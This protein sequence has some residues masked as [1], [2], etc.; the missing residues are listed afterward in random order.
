MPSSCTLCARFLFVCV[1]VCAAVALL[2]TFSDAARASTKATQEENG[3][4]HTILRPLYNPY[5]RHPPLSSLSIQTESELKAGTNT[6]AETMKNPPDKEDFLVTGYQSRPVQSTQG[7]LSSGKILDDKHIEPQLGITRM[8]RGYYM[9]RVKPASTVYT[10][11][12]ERQRATPNHHHLS[13]TQAPSNQKS[14]FVNF[15]N[16]VAFGKHTVSDRP[17][18]VDIVARSGRIFS[19]FPPIIRKTSQSE[20]FTAGNPFHQRSSLSV[21]KNP[22][23]AQESYGQGKFPGRDF[24]KSGRYWSSSLPSSGG[25]YGGYKEANELALPRTWSASSRAQLGKFPVFTSQTGPYAPSISNGLISGTKRNLSPEKLPPSITNYSQGLRSVSSNEKSTQRNVQSYLFTNPGTTFVKHDTANKVMDDGQ[26]TLSGLNTFPVMPSKQSPPAPKPYSKLSSTFEQSHVSNRKDPISEIQHFSNNVNPLYNSVNVVQYGSQTYSEE[27]TNG[28][29]KYQ[30][31]LSIYRSPLRTAAHTPSRTSLGPVSDK[32]K[33]LKS[34]APIPLVNSQDT[35]APGS[36]K[37]TVRSQVTT[38][39]LGEWARGSKLGRSTKSIYGFRGFKY[40][41][42]WTAVGENGKASVL[43][44]RG[45]IGRTKSQRYSFDKTMDYRLKSAS[46]Y[47]SLFPKYGFGESRTKPTAAPPSLSETKRRPTGYSGPNVT[48]DADANKTSEPVST[49]SVFLH[50]KSSPRDYKYKTSANV[51]FPGLPVVSKTSPT[52]GIS[53]DDDQTTSV[54]TPKAFKSGAEDVQPFVGNNPDERQFRSNKRIHALK[55]LYAP[56]FRTA[57]SEQVEGAKT[58]VTGTDKSDTVLQGPESFGSS[59]SQIWQPKSGTIQRRYEPFTFKSMHKQNSVRNGPSSAPVEAGIH[60]DYSE[61]IKIEAILRPD[62]IQ[63][64]S[65]SSA[66]TEN[67]AIIDRSSSHNVNITRTNSDLRPKG[68]IDPK[69]ATSEFNPFIPSTYKLFINSGVST[70]VF[71]AARTEIKNVQGSKVSSKTRL[72]NVHLGSDENQTALTETEPD[73]ISATSTQ[74]INDL[75]SKDLKSL[76]KTAGSIA[77]VTHS[78]HVYDKHKKS[79]KTYAFLGFQS[80]RSKI[81]GTQNKTHWNNAEQNTT[82]ASPTLRHSSAVP[83]SAM[84]PKDDPLP[85]KS[86]PAPKSRARNNAKPNP[87]KATLLKPQ[88]STYSMVRGNRVQGRIIGGQN[89]IKSNDTALN[90]D[91]RNAPIFR[92]PKHPI[93]IEAIMY[94]DILGSA[95]FS[96]IREKTG[97]TTAYN[98]SVSNTTVT[99]TEKTEVDAPQTGNVSETKAE[100]SEDAAHISGEEDGATEAQAKGEMVDGGFSRGKTNISGTGI[101]DADNKV[102]SSDALLD[103]EGSGGLNLPDNLP[104]VSSAASESLGED[105]LELNYL[106]IATGNTSFKSM[107]LSHADK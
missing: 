77:S 93:S 19:T 49:S 28:V 42:R 25:H 92:P 39:Q 41:P 45:A 72:S 70:D 91:M 48:R 44:S 12:F 31:E 69:E 63:S 9:K 89:H 56:P 5:S 47:P 54:F 36:D 58:L 103:E 26:K 59:S 73:N 7:S 29:S 18:S 82:T 87:M 4:K 27:K 53:V 66:P 2:V 86:S 43:P 62:I 68:S 88:T 21:A 105:L 60:K 37:L 96:G 107:K 50:I 67:E 79:R 38:A 35:D 64:I 17:G 99:T 71:S 65:H 84:D 98:Q 24:S 51:F 81:G 90:S 74:S 33:D 14:Q 101:E 97:N 78:R 80:A 104:A 11:S 15:Q 16:A 95:S 46:V 3:V 52:P 32:G 94:A 34:F 40:N 6:N 102:T 20:D 1:L 13:H 55:G 85:G 61:N 23:D 57:T 100:T 10:G 76:P 106:Q 75:S 8:K 30:P 83:A 22:S